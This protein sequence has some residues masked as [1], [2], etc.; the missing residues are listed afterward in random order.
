M[1]Q[2]EAL[3]LQ[4]VD[5]APGL[6]DRRLDQGLALAVV[7][8]V[9]GLAL[10]GLQPR[11]G[12]ARRRRDLPGDRHGGLARGDAAAAGADIDLHEAFEGDAVLH[13][14]RREVVDIAEVVDADQHPRPRGERRQAIDLLRRDHLV[15]DQ[16]V[17]DAGTHQRLGLA[18]LLAADAA[19]AAPLDLHHRD[20]GRL[21]GLG[22]R[23]V[24]QAVRLHEAAELLDVALE[25]VEIDHQAGGVDLL[26]RHADAGGNVVAHGCVSSGLGQ[27]VR[28]TGRGPEVRRCAASP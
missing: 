2:V 23:P 9:L 15:G 18:D 26:D 24:A 7:A 25:R 21:V 17:A 4:E 8:H 20:V 12:Q 3:G 28:V 14:R 27:R 1:A 11:E 13:G 16:H 19:G 6:V 5:G 10:V 22:V